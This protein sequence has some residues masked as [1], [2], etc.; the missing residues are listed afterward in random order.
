MTDIRTIPQ[1]ILV[2]LNYSCSSSPSANILTGSTTP[3]TVRTAPII[4]LISRGGGCHLSEK[5]AF[6][7]QAYMGA[8]FSAFVVYS[9]DSNTQTYDSLLT[10][11][12]TQ[13]VNLPAVYVDEDVGHML[14]GQLANA[15]AVQ[16]SGLDSKDYVEVVLAM[17]ADDV[18]GVV[19]PQ[20]LATYAPLNV[21]EIG[22]IVGCSLAI[23]LGVILVIFWNRLFCLRP[24]DSAARFMAELARAAIEL[25]P[26]GLTLD[27]ATLDTFPITRFGLTQAKNV[28]C[29]ICLVDF[30]E[31]R[32]G[33]VKQK[34]K[35]VVEREEA[36]VEGEEATIEEKKAGIEGDEAEVKG[37]EA[38]VER[39]EAESSRTSGEAGKGK[40][41]KE[42]P[43]EG[44]SASM[45]DGNKIKGAQ[46]NDDKGK[47]ETE[48]VTRPNEEVR[49]L[50]CGHVY[51]VDCIVYYS[52]YPEYL[53]LDFFFFFFFF[54]SRDQLPPTDP[55][56]TE[57]SPYCPVC[58]L[59]L[60]PKEVQERQ[61]QLRMAAEQAAREAVATAE[62]TQ[63]MA[64]EDMR[65]RSAMLADPIRAQAAAAASAAI[66]AEGIAAVWRQVARLDSSGA[67]VDEVQEAEE[68]TMI[69]MSVMGMQPEAVIVEMNDSE[70]VTSAGA[71][72]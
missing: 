47:A 44:S 63:R 16:A 3:S 38:R 72:V 9:N 54:S 52:C 39:E 32:E 62:A 41:G 26:L 59:N 67:Q 8:N 43:A 25:R 29:P 53:T 11:Q 33:V 30:E 1:G 56:L 51:H 48:Q 22:I 36:G 15:E 42:E 46:V 35:V 24:P 14:L 57:R 7:Q 64:E 68:S 70:I 65:T 60:L 45:A 55:W 20:A 50:P 4:G 13:Q 6:A 19:A 58:K 23:L 28:G 21:T 69:E 17:S 71:E 10:D 34:V 5:L 37:A 66:V 61:K 12:G 18:M 2:D 49:V 27:Q 40:E 31:Q